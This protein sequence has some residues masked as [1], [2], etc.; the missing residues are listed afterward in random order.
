MHV[1]FR[2]LPA[3]GVTG[4]RRKRAP[5]GRWLA[6]GAAALAVALTSVTIVRGQT[7]SQITPPTFRP[8]LPAVGGS[9]VFSGEPGLAAPAGAVRDAGLESL[10]VSAL[11]LAGEPLRAREVA[12]MNASLSVLLRAGLR[13]ADP[14]H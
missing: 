5:V 3:A 13:G 2:S 10:Y 14:T 9:V 4:A 1:A 8:D 12:T 11:L 6:S 7:A